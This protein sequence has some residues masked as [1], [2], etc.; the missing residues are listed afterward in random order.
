MKYRNLF[1]LIIFLSI[2]LFA[3][4]SILASSASGNQSNGSSSNIF[5][6][7]GSSSSNSI[8]I[9]TVCGGVSCPMPNSPNS[10][11]V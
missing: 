8:S 1:V 7:G 4:S 10:T 6:F 2:A 11:S 3:T 5:E 9:N